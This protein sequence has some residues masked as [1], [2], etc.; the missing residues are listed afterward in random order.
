MSIDASALERYLDLLEASDATIDR[1]LARRLAQTVD[2]LA[3]SAQGIAHRASGFMADSIHQLGP[4]SLGGDVLESQIASLA[5]YTDIE[6]D[7]GE[8]HD[9]ASRTLVDEAAELDTLSDA[10]GR[11]VVAAVGGA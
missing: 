8:T 9:W 6:L 4:S 7:R 1:D 5:S 2:K 10:A 3:S 11:I